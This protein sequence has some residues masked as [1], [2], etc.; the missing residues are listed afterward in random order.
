[1]STIASVLNS[2]DAVGE[3]TLTPERSRVGFANKTMWGLMTVTGHFTDVR[4]RGQIT[5]GGTVSGQLDIDA[6]TV[7]TGLPMRD[8]H[9]RSPDFLNVDRFPAITV[10]VTETIPGDAD[11]TD[12][13]SFITVTG[14]TTPLTLHA[15]VELLDDAAVRLRTEITIDRDK[16]GVR[17][18]KLHMLGRTVTLSADTVFRRSSTTDPQND[19]T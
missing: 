4:G 5:A 10:V 11:I 6:A 19:D 17:F 7:E 3:W 2:P 13:D 9:L 16:L 14:T 1:M 18:N 15:N 12:L 8:R